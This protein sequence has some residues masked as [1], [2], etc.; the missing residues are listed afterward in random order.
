KKVEVASDLGN[1]ILRAEEK[2]VNDAL[3]LAGKDRK[4]LLLPCTAT[5][6][7]GRTI[8]KRTPLQ[9]AAMAGDFDLKNRVKEEKNRGLVER[10][11][12][13]GQLS[14]E[15]VAEQLREVLTSKEAIA[16]NEKRN[17]RIFAAIKAF[18]E[19]LIKCKDYKLEKKTQP[20]AE[21]LKK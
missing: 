9:I 10:L 18:G 1:L 6:L 5:D 8:L 17:Q 21:K 12:L 11:Q 2:D 4:L 15:E 13:A 16:E 7:Q 14:D 19:D 3:A 20:L